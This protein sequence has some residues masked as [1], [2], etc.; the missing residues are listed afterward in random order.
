MLQNIFRQLSSEAVKVSQS[1]TVSFIVE[2]LVRLA[3]RAQLTMLLEQLSVDWEVVC[4]HQFASHVTQ[5]VVNRCGY[6]ICKRSSL[7][8]CT[9][10][11]LS[12]T[13]AIN[14]FSLTRFLFFA[15]FL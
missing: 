2:E 13:A 15:D 10:Y 1:P 5:A 6:F 11:I 7:P 9:H 8:P 14:R 12:T 4:C 3:D